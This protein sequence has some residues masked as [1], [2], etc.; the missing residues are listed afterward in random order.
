MGEDWGSGAAEAPVPW[1]GWEKE[2]GGVRLGGGGDVL[3]EGG[4]WRS[5]RNM[6]RGELEREAGVGEW[7]RLGFDLP[8]FVK[9]RDPSQAPRCRSEAKCFIGGGLVLVVLS[10]KPEGR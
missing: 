4:W 1:L 9:M 5:W 2:V 10:G 3:G 6:E 7:K 8:A